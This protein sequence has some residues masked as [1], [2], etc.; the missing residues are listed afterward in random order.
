MSIS[1]QRTSFALDEATIDALRRL[2]RRWHVSQAEVVRRAVRLAMDRSEG[3][4]VSVQERLRTYRSNRRIDP[5]K[6][7]EYLRR[8]AEDR[9]RWGRDR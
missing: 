1:K 2:S 6:A 9:E 5:V 8:V 4:A 3:E 7:D